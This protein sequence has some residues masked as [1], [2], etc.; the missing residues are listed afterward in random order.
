MTL[1]RIPASATV[2]V[3]GSVTRPGPPSRRTICNS[4]VA[5][6]G[7]GALHRLATCACSISMSSAPAT[8]SRCCAPSGI[9]TATAS[10][11]VAAEPV[12]ACDSAML[13]LLFFLKVRLISLLLGLSL[14]AAVGV[15]DGGGA[16]ASR[17]DRKNK[18]IPVAQ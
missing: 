11:A 15:P 10:G 12:D 13:L 6:A 4:N 14:L 9:R 1:A 17:S 3:V 5:P 2:P 8:V 18:T 7:V 16:R